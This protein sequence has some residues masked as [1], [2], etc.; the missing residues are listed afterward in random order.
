MIGN[1]F[2]A[3]PVGCWKHDDGIHGSGCMWCTPVKST[4]IGNDMTV[5]GACADFSVQLDLDVVERQTMW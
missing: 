4:T 3:T 5:K 1:G 2:G